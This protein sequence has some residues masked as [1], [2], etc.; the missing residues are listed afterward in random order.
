MQLAH[1][2]SGGAV[3]IAARAIDPDNGVDRWVS[4]HVI[5]T[6]A[7]D[8]RPVF[9]VS[10]QVVNVRLERRAGPAGSSAMNQV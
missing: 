1:G 8:V 4:R 6:S 3:Y 5:D 2:A 7:V 9:R 10:Q